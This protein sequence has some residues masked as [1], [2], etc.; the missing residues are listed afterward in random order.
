MCDLLAE[1]FSLESDF[2]P[3]REKQA[4]GLSALI[5]APSE[6]TLMLVAIVEGLVVGMATIQTLIST[7]EGGCVGL[8]E[9]V[10]VGKEYRSR[11]IGTTLLDEIVRW[12]MERK[13]F[14]LQLVADKDNQP[15]LKFYLSQKWAVTN[16]M[17]MRK[18]V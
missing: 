14:R 6:T 1:L 5:A 18:I 7:A 17:C 8:V 16:L 12:G 15:A 9:D 3:D 13:L 4:R 2:A 10:V 11:G